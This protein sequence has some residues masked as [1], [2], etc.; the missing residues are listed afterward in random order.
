MNEKEVLK[1][2]ISAMAILIIAALDAIRIPPGDETEMA[3]KLAAFLAGRNGARL[4]SNSPEESKKE[5]EL[6]L[7][8][9]V[10]GR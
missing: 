3:L 5:I 9:L 4:A 7:E 8:F 10:S 6:E 2:N 1:A